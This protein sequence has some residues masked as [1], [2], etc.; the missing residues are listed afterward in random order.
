M[1]LKVKN[2][3]EI[4]GNVE[5][6]SSKSYTH[7]A[8]IIASFASGV[9]RIFNPLI[10][11]DTRASIKACKYFGAEINY[12]EEDKYLEIKGTDEIKNISKKP[13][14]LK[15]SGT[16]LRIMTSI[17]GLSKT[18]S[19]LTGDD[20]LKN[21][22]MGILLDALKPL[23]ANIKSLKN[24][25]KPPLVIKSG[26]VG[27]KTSVKGDISSQF[28]SSLLI[29]GPISKNGV[30]VEVKGKFVSKSYII[31]TIDVMKKFGVDVSVKQGIGSDFNDKESSPLLIEDFNNYSN[32]IS[33]IIKP[34][35]YQGTDFEVEG[36]YS[37]SSYLLAAVAICGGKITMRN[38]FKE[39]K[40]GD[41]LILDILEKLGSKIIITNDSVTLLSDGKLNGIDI[42]LN[43]A[44]D[45][46]PT[47]AVLAALSNGKTK[48]IG[49]EHGRYKET[50]R[51]KVCTTE[52]KKLGC[53]IKE[54][55]DGME[56]IGGIDSGIVNSHHDHRIAM[57]FSLIGL[58]HEI[59]VENGEVFNVSFPNF[60]E[61][62][63]EIGIDLELN[64]N[65]FLKK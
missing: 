2:V 43:N 61:S 11:E 25:E 44:P 4:C 50:D 47:V 12:D 23:G 3:H 52:L 36:D 35:K 29:A 45:L 65:K 60:I 19:L 9:S 10:S 33:F 14:D 63:K 41:K 6:P 17:A 1:F 30:E 49:V 24:N 51:I 8:I 18:K 13:I 7:R 59:L 62:M 27:G 55:L 46:L 32:P 42:D 53:E 34:Q 56:I 31:M 20:S 16:T 38:L 57:A 5:A 58:K 40:Q 37:S 64:D 21:R 15:N 54:N 22:P 28:L 26:F 48:I 39:S